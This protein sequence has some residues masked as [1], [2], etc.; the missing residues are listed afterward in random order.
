MKFNKLNKL[1]QIF[2]SQTK[3]YKGLKGF[4]PA[5]RHGDFIRIYLEDINKDPTKV[6]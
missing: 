5:R 6:W 4:F 1:N 2:L 3:G